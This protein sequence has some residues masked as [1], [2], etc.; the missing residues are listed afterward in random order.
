MLLYYARKWQWMGSLLGH[1]LLSWMAVG[2][3]RRKKWSLNNKSSCARSLNKIN[4]L[5]PAIVQWRTF[6]RERQ[7]NQLDIRPG[8][9]ILVA[10]QIYWTIFRK[11][12]FY[13]R[14]Q[15]TTIVFG[16]SVKCRGKRNCYVKFS[17]LSFALLILCNNLPLI[18]SGHLPSQNHFDNSHPSSLSS[19]PILFEYLLTEYPRD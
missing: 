14:S 10:V 15:T 3:Y 2:R 8:N 17:W 12:F 7:E 5:I 6:N 18:R 1:C 19:L 9:R 16:V 4:S 11:L 13:T